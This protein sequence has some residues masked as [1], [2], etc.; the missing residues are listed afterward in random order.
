MRALPRRVSHLEKITERFRSRPF[1]VLAINTHPKENFKVKGFIAG[2]G[3]QF[4]ALE[5][6]TDDWAEKHYKVVGTPSNFLIDET[7]KIVAEPRLYD[8][9]TEDRLGQLI[10]ELLAKNGAAPGK[11][12]S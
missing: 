12:G 7:G 3:Y 6:P 2:N 5:T 4:H 9:E 8:Q 11:S 10:T 1:T